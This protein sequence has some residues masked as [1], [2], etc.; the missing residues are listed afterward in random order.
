MKNRALSLLLTVSLLTIPSIVVTT[1]TVGCIAVMPGENAVVVRAE[2][3]ISGTVDTLD[4][5]FKFEKDNRA[6]LGLEFKQKV[7][8]L[9]KNAPPAIDTV[10]LSLKAY[11]QTRTPEK[12]ATLEG[13]LAILQVLAS[14]AAKLQ[15]PTTVT[16]PPPT[17]GDPPKPPTQ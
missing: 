16:P 11:K 4:A 1:L 3:T 17:I 8:N 15:V 12:K 14:E 5:L 2:Q 13:A 9:R 6:I 7:D 10:K